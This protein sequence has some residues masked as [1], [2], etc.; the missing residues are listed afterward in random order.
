MDDS[1][2]L[3]ENEIALNPDTPEEARSALPDEAECP[4]SSGSELARIAAFW[5]GLKSG[6]PP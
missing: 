4:C 5:M 3:P 1:P 6:S 2:S